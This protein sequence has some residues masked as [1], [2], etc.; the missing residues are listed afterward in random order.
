L[1]P[2][3]GQIPKDP[4]QENQDSLVGEGLKAFIE[5]NHE[6][7]IT[8]HMSFSQNP[9]TAQNQEA[10]SVLFAHVQEHQALKYRIQVQE[11][12]AQQGIELPPEGE[13]IP[14]EIQNQIAM[15]AAEATQQIT[16]QEQ[17]MIE[18]QQI[19]QQQ[20]QIQ[21][22]QQQLELQAAEVQRKTQA[23][24][25]RAQTEL[26]KAEIDAEIEIMKA[27]K[28]E[29]IAQQ[30]IA[31]NREKEAMEAELKSQKTYADILKQVKD[32]E[33]KSEKE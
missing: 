10:V 12:L 3:K 22:A 21:L 26:T 25:L 32:A 24:Q 33:K 1:E 7:H 29:D 14:P 4:I 11:L 28:T 6:A 20:P 13:E 30:R 17:A 9:N 27:D 2:E 15:L 5:Q 19:A 23:D 18:A 31:A 16:G 8:T